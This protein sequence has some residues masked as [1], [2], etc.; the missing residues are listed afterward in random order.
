MATGARPACLA[1]PVGH[2]LGLLKA[3]H[4]RRLV[5]GLVGMPGAGKSTFARRLAQ[6]VNLAAGAPLMATVAMDG[7][8]LSRAVLTTFPDPAAALSRRGAPWTFDAAAL[9]ARVLA[10]RAQAATDPG[11]AVKWPTFDH[12]VGDPVPDALSIGAEVQVVLVEGLYLLHRSHGWQLDGLLDECWYL[13]VDMNT[14][15]DRI[16]ARHQAS[17]SLTREQAQLRV[18]RND[19]ENAGFVLLSRDRADWLV[20]C[21]G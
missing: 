6:D 19:R 3:A 5:L 20:R 18:D 4:P 17:W 11:H 12:G 21:A 16:V 15:M 8:H 2:V 7:F 10:L 13:D 14:A 9:A 1:D